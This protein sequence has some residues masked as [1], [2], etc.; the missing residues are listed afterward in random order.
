VHGDY[1]ARHIAPRVNAPRVQREIIHLL[2]QE[3]NEN[4]QR[5]IIDE[6]ADNR[7]EYAIW[8]DH[9]DMNAIRRAV[10]APQPA[11]W[12][13]LVVGNLDNNNNNGKNIRIRCKT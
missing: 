10:N 1:H 12:D 13:Q 4:V 7:G 5:E 2:Q 11:V 3:E 6:I 9:F 8:R